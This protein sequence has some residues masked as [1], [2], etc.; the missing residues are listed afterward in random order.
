MK[1]NM[2]GSGWHLYHSI[3]LSVSLQQISISLYESNSCLYFHI[4]SQTNKVATEKVRVHNLVVLK[5]TELMFCLK[6]CQ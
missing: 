4:F 6:L 2:V 5:I 1:L 3:L